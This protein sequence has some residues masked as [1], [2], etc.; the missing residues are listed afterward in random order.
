MNHFAL[1]NSL[2]PSKP[3][4]PA[5]PTLWQRFKNAPANQPNGNCSR[6]EVLGTSASI[7]GGGLVLLGTGEDATLVGAVVGVP[8]QVVGTGLGFAGLLVAG[9][10]LIGKDLGLCQ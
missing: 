2:A 7:T 8:T 4:P 9:V 3:T 10:G 6:A 5:P 1:C